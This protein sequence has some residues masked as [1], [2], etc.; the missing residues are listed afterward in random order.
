VRFAV[1]REPQSVE[2]IVAESGGA[3]PTALTAL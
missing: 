2:E 3:R 1:V